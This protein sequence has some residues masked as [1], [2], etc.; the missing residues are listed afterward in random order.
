MACWL[1]RASGSIAV[2]GE[3]AVGTGHGG[4][5]RPFE[6]LSAA[7]SVQSAKR[8]VD[9]SSVW[10]EI[11]SVETTKAAP[12]SR[13]TFATGGTLRLSRTWLGSIRSS[14]RL[15]VRKRSAPTSA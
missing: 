15:K 9:P 8:A 6:T 7:D 10:R 1:K 2:A 11:A 4:T 13:S 3:E 12:A 14:K 5:G